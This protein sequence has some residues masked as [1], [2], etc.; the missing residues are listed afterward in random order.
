MNMKCGGL[1]IGDLR[2]P[3]HLEIVGDDEKTRMGDGGRLGD[4]VE[5]EVENITRW[6]KK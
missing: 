6:A 1:N 4:S 2:A 3:A 5:R